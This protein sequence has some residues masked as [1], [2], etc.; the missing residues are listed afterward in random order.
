MERGTAA[1]VTA[2]LLLAALPLASCRRDPRVLP[3]GTGFTLGAAASARRSLV[4]IVPATEL[5]TC[6]SVAADL[7]AAQASPGGAAPLTVV[8]V[9]PHADWMAAYLRSQRLAA[10]LVPMGR[11][12][13]A[14]RF[15]YEAV[16]A[17]YLVDGRRIARAMEIGGPGDVRSWLRELARAPE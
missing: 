11:A 8:Y 12:G 10:V 7:R 14:R 16:P 5:R 15:G 2:A 9:G 4:W 6:G 1:R 13:Y 17:L 3:P